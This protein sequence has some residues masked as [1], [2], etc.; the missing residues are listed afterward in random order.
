M[1]INIDTEAYTAKKICSQGIRFRI[2]LYQRPYT[3][4]K[5]QVRQLL[6]D[7][8]ECYDPNKEDNP[9]YIGIMN[10]AATEIDEKIFD[11][12]DGQ[13]RITTLSIMALVLEKWKGSTQDEF[14]WSDF[15][16]KLSFYGREE[17]QKFL[18]YG[19]MTLNPTANMI[20]AKNEIESFVN[21]KIE[22]AQREKFSK[23]VF[24]NASFFLT[25]IPDDYTII[26]KNNQFVRMNNRGKQ[27]EQVDI[28]KVM[29]SRI[30][31]VD[32]NFLSV[33]NTISQ[34]NCKQDKDINQDNAGDGLTIDDIIKNEISFKEKGI[35]YESILSFE[36][37]LL[38][39]LDRFLNKPDNENKSSIS[40]DTSKL[41]ETFGF[42]GVKKSL[43]WKGDVVND[44]IVFLN[45]QFELFTKYFIQ[46]DKDDNWQN[47][48]VPNSDE[49]NWKKLQQF[50]SYLYVSREP[51]EWM[52]EAFDWLENQNQD[53]DAKSF[54]QELKRIDNKKGLSLLPNVKSQS[55]SI[56]EFVQVCFNDTHYPNINRYWFWRLDYYL[57]EENEDSKKKDGAIS[58]YIFRT[59]RSIEHLHPQNQENETEKWEDKD[60]N[61]FG[62]LAMISSG[63]NSTQS[64]DPVRV[65]FSRIE[66]QHKKEQLQSIKLWK[67]HEIVKGNDSGWTTEIAKQHKTA[68][69]EILENSFKTSSEK[70][71]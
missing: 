62:N 57:W 23:Y 70:E 24:K 9:Y 27:L 31:G 54:L 29:L 19:S 39:A 46:K 18:Q 64:N 66:D 37:F 40:H 56:K 50:Q 33:W 61:S 71:E 3:W 38:I 58:K 49:K 60:L 21:E 44:F 16:G 67:M 6:D 69:L 8:L 28:L 5:R 47:I 25:K 51:H 52:N 1:S 53:L 10:V 2:P 59:N 48:E 12:I 14:D 63:F 42:S 65:K 34:M 4:E 22:N 45:K 41:L 68:M 36:E 55:Q 30:Q 11:L 17:D 43:S 13:Q 20:E 15:C 32:D 26:D 7:L 35:Y